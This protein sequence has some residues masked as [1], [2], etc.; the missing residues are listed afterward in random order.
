M[1]Q[2]ATMAVENVGGI[3]SLKREFKKGLN[4]IELPNSAGKTSFC[5]GL[6]LLALEQD[7]L[8]DKAH[9]LNLFAGYNGRGRV[10]FQDDQQKVERTFTRGAKGLMASGDSLGGDAA[11]LVSFATLDN[12]IIVK[13]LAGESLKPEFE[14]LSN[15]KAFDVSIRFYEDK[16]SEAKHR[17]SRLGRRS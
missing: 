17:Y 1:T 10:L 4:I 3:E 9:Y 12:R 13:S 8:R 2:M 15:S 7:E 11:W 16:T 6:E 5:R 14:S